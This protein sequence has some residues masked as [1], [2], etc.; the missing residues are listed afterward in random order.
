MKTALSIVLA[1][2]VLAVQPSRAEEANEPKAGLCEAAFVLGCLAAAGWLVFYVA[3][4]SKEPCCIGPGVVVL[5][6]DPYAGQWEAVATN[7]IPVMCRTNAVEVFRASM[8][9]AGYR[10]RAKFYPTKE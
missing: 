7:R 5:E 6:R 4:K 9:E 10:Y 1:L 8:T 3:N 2:A